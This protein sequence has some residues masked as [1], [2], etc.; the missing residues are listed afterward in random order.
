MAAD[1]S[2]T[3]NQR[4]HFMELFHEHA[5]A[6]RNF[7]WHPD[8]IPICLAPS[9]ASVQTIIMRRTA[10]THLAASLVA[11]CSRNHRIALAH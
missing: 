8:P 6:M 2:A 10:V 1:Y 4:R 9:G 7:A 3:K 11:G 5:D